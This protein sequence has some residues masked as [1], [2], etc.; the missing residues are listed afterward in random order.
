MDCAYCG[1]VLGEG[2]Y[3]RHCGTPVNARLATR[4][5]TAE[6]AAVP[7]PRTGPPSPP[8]ELGP[9]PSS[10]RFPMYADEAGRAR[11]SGSEPLEA[12][13]GEWIFGRSGTEELP[14]QRVEQPL[15]PQSGRQPPA[16]HLPPGLGEDLWGDGPLADDRPAGGPVP[17]GVP[18]RRVRARRRAGQDGVPV[19]IVAVSAA[20]LVLLLAAWLMRDAGRQEPSAA[21]SERSGS[22]ADGSGGGAASREAA[23]LLGEAEVDVPAVAAPQLSVSGEQVRYDA[24]NLVDGD[25]RTAW[26]MAGDGTG[27]SLTIT[28]PQAAVVSRVGLVNGYAKVDDSGSDGSVDW[29]PR[30]RRILEV[31]WTFDDDTSVTQRLQERPDPQYLDVPDVT[32]TTLTLTLDRVS[33]PAS[34]PSGRDYTA[35]SELTVLGTA[36]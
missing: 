9:A 2:P 33:D 10:A 3:C 18:G 23:S 35:I 27:T 22:V 6:R 25:P 26:R 31:T 30:N 17:H 32:T 19:A 20:L 36:R 24:V 8:P 12:G 4:T 28:L 5:D 14:A 34:G 15:A 21:R 29:Y 11:A 7:M 13:P 1:G 16:A